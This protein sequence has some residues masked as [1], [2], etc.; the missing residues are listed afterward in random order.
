MRKDEHTI[1][2]SDIQ[3]LK[4]MALDEDDLKVISAC[5]QDAVFKS[6]DMAYL[7][8]DQCFALVGNRFV[9]ERTLS[10]AAY[11][12]RR[13]GLHI[14][15]VQSVKSQ[16]IDPSDKGI[17]LSL[18]AITFVPHESPSGQIHLHFADNKTICLDVE[19]LEISM[20]DLGAMWTTDQK[21]EHKIV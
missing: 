10:D 9:W 18:L 1:E 6:S 15:R 13:T 17:I 7:P 16:N 21:P 5:F 12:R 14:R 4:L 19:C 20:K 3:P 11:Q 2:A 8:K